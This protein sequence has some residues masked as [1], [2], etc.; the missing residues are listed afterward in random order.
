MEIFELV[1]HEEYYQQVPPKRNETENTENQN[2][3]EHSTEIVMS[4]LNEKNNVD[5]SKKDPD[6][7]K[8]DIIIHK[9]F[10]I[11][12]K[13]KP[14]RFINYQNIQTDNIAELNDLRRKV[15][16]HKVN[17]HPLRESDQKYKT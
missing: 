2:I 7:K 4:K 12:I 10:R 6:R 1:N 13:Y 9:E 5:L 17:I 15:F 11:R 3:A 8:G 16:S 14:K